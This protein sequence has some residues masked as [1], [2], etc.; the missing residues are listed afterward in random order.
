[1]MR[2]KPMLA[3]PVSDKP[4]DYNKP[5]FI[6]PKLDG[7]RCLIQY[8]AG[9]VTAYSRT[10]KVWQNIEHITLNLYKFF[11]KHPNV[12]LDG[13]LYNHDFKDDFESIISMVRKTKPTAE[14]RVISSDNVQFHCYDTIMEHMPYHDRALFL[15]TNLKESYCVKFLPPVRVDSDERAKLY[16]QENLGAGYEGSILRTNDIYKCG[17]SWSLRKFKDFSDAEATI[18]GYV[19]GKGK[20]EGTLGKF[21]MRDDDGIEF[22]CPPGKGYNYKD[23]KDMLDNIHDYIGQRATFTFF[24]RT[25][26]NSYRHP[27]FKC[28]RNYE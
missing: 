18:I 19:D 10:G 15:I 13:E 25:K 9:K 27:L 4:V 16:H 6:Q 14:D 28:I 17:R 23:M 3:Y 12:I 22:G 2:K 11:D 1:M 24:E 26:A 7:V 20:R 8:D 21:L 5:V